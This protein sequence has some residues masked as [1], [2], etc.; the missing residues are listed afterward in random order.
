VRDVKHI[1]LPFSADRFPFSSIEINGTA[2]DVTC[3]G[4]ALGAVIVPAP[5][6]PAPAGG[7]A[8]KYVKMLTPPDRRP[9]AAVT[10]GALTKILGA[11]VVSTE[12]TCDDCDGTDR[13][14]DADGDCVCSNCRCAMCT[15]GKTWSR[16]D[17]RDVTLADVDINANLAAVALDAVDAQSGSGKIEIWGFPGANVLFVAT[18]WRAVVV[19]GRHSDAKAPRH[20]GGSAT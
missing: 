20:F 7:R 17:V 4:H 9:D 8:D 12:A 19:V 11:A 13:A 16:P 3:N 5:N 15:G 6:Y 2:W 18:W 1:A 10:F 14:R